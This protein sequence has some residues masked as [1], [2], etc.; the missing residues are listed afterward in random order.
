MVAELLLVVLSNT[1][2]GDHAH[3]VVA[4]VVGEFLGAFHQAAAVVPA[5]V[6]LSFTAD[7]DFR[8][9]DVKFSDQRRVL[10]F[11][12]NRPFGSRNRQKPMSRSFSES[13]NKMKCSVSPQVL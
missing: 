12:L 6:G 5:L 2:T 13:L 11:R 10:E 1:T 4:D 3:R 9:V 7:G 8:A